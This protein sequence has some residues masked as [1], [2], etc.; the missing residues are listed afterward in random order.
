MITRKL[1]VLPLLSGLFT[2]RLAARLIRKIYLQEAPRSILMKL[3]CSWGSVT[4]GFSIV[5]FSDN[6]TKAQEV[7]LE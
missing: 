4:V 7:A 3:S 6:D 5:H 2:L 1:R